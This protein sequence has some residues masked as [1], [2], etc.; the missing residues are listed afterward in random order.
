MERIQGDPELAWRVLGLLNLYRLLLPTVIGLVVAMLPGSESF[1]SVAPKLFWFA[2]VGWFI[3]GIGCIA[4]LKTRRPDLQLQAYAHI[5]IDVV[6][7]TVLVFASGGVA[8]G[9]GLLLIVPVGGVSL[10]VANRTAFL[11]AAVASVSLLSQ[12]A[13]LVATR[14]DDVTSFTQ[15]GLLGAIIFI[16]ALAAA[17]LANR[18]RESEEKVRER[19]IDL[20][21]LAELSQYVVERLRES[22]VVVDA[23]DRIRLI[24]ESAMQI[25]GRGNARNGALLG[26]VSPQLLYQLETWRQ[27]PQEDFAGSTMV[28]SDGAREIYPHFASLGGAQPAPVIIFLEDLS[29]VSAKL[30]QSKLAALGRLSASIAHEIRN[31]VGAMSHAAQLLSE[32]TTLSDGDRRLTEII[33]K[34]GARVSTIIDN[35]MQLSRR[36][37]TRPERIPLATWVRDFIDEFRDTVELPESRFALIL[38]EDDMEVRVDPTQLHQI[39]WNLCDNAR[40][41]GLKD[42]QSRIEVSAGRLSGSARPYLEIADRGAGISPNAAFRI[43]EPFFTE[44]AG[45][46]GLGLFISRELAQCNGALLTHEHRPGGGSIF[47][48]VFAD[49]LRWEQA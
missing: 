11:I 7:V 22:I 13:V 42:D 26:E 43:F 31:P 5:V 3:A 15:A 41:Y 39:L 44:H 20:A 29:A 33:R 48:V 17:P 6:A 34:N 32:S 16:V 14:I 27:N 19:E 28:A 40:K 24:N 36:E 25:L 8:S 2:L 37:E 18:M 38:P 4:M 45:G 46:T 1:A 9:L 10:L 35:V 12:Q 47:R 49:P 21:N 30:Q 23:T